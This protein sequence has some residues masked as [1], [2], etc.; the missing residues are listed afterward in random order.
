VPAA[1][2]LRDHRPAT[3]HRCIRAIAWRF[4]SNQASCVQAS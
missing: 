2:R 3:A 4:P 1:L